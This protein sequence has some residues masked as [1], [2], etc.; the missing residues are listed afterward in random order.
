MFLGWWISAYP[1]EKKMRFREPPPAIN[2]E[3]GLLKGLARCLGRGSPWR[4]NRWKN[5]EQR[6][7]SRGFSAVRV[8]RPASLRRG[9]EKVF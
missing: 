8:W 6:R 4:R 7:T 5:R 3:R 1:Q 9:R 2:Q